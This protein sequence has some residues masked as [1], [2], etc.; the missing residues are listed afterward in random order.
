M[1]V[2]RPLTAVFAAVMS[3]FNIGAAAALTP[4][5]TAPEFK[6]PSVVDGKVVEFNLKDALAKHAVILYFFPQAFS[7]G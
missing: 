2:M 5:N 3:L 4:G 7:A 6:A 1:K